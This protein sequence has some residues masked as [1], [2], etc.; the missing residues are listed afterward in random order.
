MA[1]S[2]VQ[3]INKTGY[4]DDKGKHRTWTYRVIFDAIPSDPADALTANDGVTAIPAV[5]DYYPGSLTIRCKKVGEATQDS[6][7]RLVFTIPVEFTDDTESTDFESLLVENPIDRP[8][9]IQFGFI[10]Y[11]VP[12][13][14]DINGEPIRNSAGD[15]FVPGLEET[16]HR[17]TCT[18]SRNLA[19]W[20]GSSRYDYM[21]TLN[22]G[23]IT[24]AGVAVGAKQALI[25]DISATAQNENGVAFV[26]ETIVIEFNDDYTRHVLDQGMYSF[27]GYEAGVG[28]VKER[29]KLNGEDVTEPQLLDG[30]G[31]KL[32]A[33]A[34]P[35]YLDFETKEATNWGALN[36]PT[37]FPALQ[38]A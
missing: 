33:G 9:D 30:A 26:R 23:A 24:I 38:G 36:L 37:T 15:E 5:G 13:E 7:S 3:I 28:D 6:N 4:N 29:I 1:V 31:K 12:V 22:S 11:T 20:D 10:T 35:V 16:E 14:S 2:T 19:T 25:K 17:M 27:D 8:P 34:A 18:I 21:D 32:A